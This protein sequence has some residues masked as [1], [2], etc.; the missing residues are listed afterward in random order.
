MSNSAETM[1]VTIAGLLTVGS[2][3]LAFAWMF[4]FPVI[5]LLWSIGWLQ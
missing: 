4:I 1:A 2:V 3:A 5:G